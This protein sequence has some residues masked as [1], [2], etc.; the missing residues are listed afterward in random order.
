MNII[1]S[2]AKQ[3]ALRDGIAA[4]HAEYTDAR[5][6]NCACSN[7][8]PCSTPLHAITKSRLDLAEAEAI[9]YLAEQVRDVF[10]GY[11]APDVARSLMASIRP[12]SAVVQHD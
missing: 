7:G 6:D 9:A 3:E 5:F 8:R 12:V 2:T 10:G 11:V 4:A 1:P